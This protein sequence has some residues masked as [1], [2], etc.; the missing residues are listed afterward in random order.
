MHKRRESPGR[1]Y[2]FVVSAASV[3][4]LTGGGCNEEDA[5][6]QANQRHL[7][8]LNETVRSLRA[9]LDDR[10]ARHEAERVKL[11]DRIGQLTEDNERLQTLG[12]GVTGVREVRQDNDARMKNL[13]AC[14]GA[15]ATILLLAASAFALKTRQEAL[16]WRALYAK[17]AGA[18][19]RWGG[20]L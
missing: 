10:K 2:L 9:E 3:I 13:L 19:I 16:R 17:E 20:P 11:N 15:V 5:S 4:L 6:D 14:Y 18:P 7:A 8:S 1:V 12:L